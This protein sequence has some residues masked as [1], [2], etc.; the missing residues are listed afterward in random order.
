[1]LLCPTHDALFDKGF[2]SFNDDGSIYISNKIDKREYELLNINKDIK[3]NFK[4]EQLPYIKWHR[5][6]EVQ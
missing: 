4:R 2:I 3:L 6:N 1:M 5:E